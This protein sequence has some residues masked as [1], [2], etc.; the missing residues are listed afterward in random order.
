LGIFLR[1]GLVGL[2]LHGL[3]SLVGFLPGS[4]LDLLALIA[5]LALRPRLDETALLGSHGSRRCG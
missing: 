2:F 4:P 5:R 1:H 3:S